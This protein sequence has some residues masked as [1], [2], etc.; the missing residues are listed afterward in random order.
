MGFKPDAIRSVV[1]LLAW[2]SASC[3]PS[4]T[5]SRPDIVG[6]SPAVAPAYFAALMDQQNGQLV[7][8]GSFI[9]PTVVLTAAHCVAGGNRMLSVVAGPAKKNDFDDALRRF[10]VKEVAVHPQFGREEMDHDIALVFL[11][12][13][14]AFR[15]MSFVKPI[16]LNR[17][18]QAPE[19]QKSAFLTIMGWGNQSNFGALVPEEFQRVDVPLISLDQCRHGNDPAYA[20]LPDSVLCAGNFLRGGVD[21]CQGDSGGPAVMTLGEN[22]QSLVGIVSWGIGCGLPQKPGVYTRVSSYVAWIDGAIARANVPLWN[23]NGTSLSQTVESHCSGR[24]RK[25]SG[26][27]RQE[28]DGDNQVVIT[29]TYAFNGVDRKGHSSRIPSDSDPDCRFDI[30]GSD[31]VMV[32]LEA[33][34]FGDTGGGRAVVTRR[35]TGETWEGDLRR[36][37][38]LTFSCNRITSLVY[39][40]V[41]FS[42]LTSDLGTFQIKNPPINIEKSSGVEDVQSCEVGSHGFSLWRGPVGSAEHPSYLLELRSPEL[43]ESPLQFELV[44]HEVGEAA[45]VRIELQGVSADRTTGNLI[46]RNEMSQDLNSWELRCLMPIEL[47]DREGETFVSSTVGLFHYLRFFAPHQ[48]Y[49]RVAG[50]QTLE[51]HYRLPNPHVTRT[52]GEPFPMRCFL[53]HQV[54]VNF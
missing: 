20:S 9:T 35:Q 52:G 5:A 37:L 38:M 41:G 44:P 17:T 34:Q 6:G 27:P 28:T 8:G 42:W 31:E 30:R 13:K 45:G 16:G 51:F 12:P 36:E 10:P 29:S 39:N 47:T 54:T 32:S 49:G 26:F 15:T 11:D 46:L 19:L 40:D 33:P 2:L 25:S 3:R 22:N 50:N 4:V 7:C 23:W 24:L 48:K 53:N 1:V 43:A 18:N 14:D 21:S